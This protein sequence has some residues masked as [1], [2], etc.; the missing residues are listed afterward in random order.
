MNLRQYAELHPVPEPEEE[1]QAAEDAAAI[2]DRRQR[3]QEEAERL[4]ES[5]SNQLDEG[6]FPQNVLYTALKLIGLLSHDQDWGE[7]QQAKIDK[8]YAGLEQQNFFIDNQAVAAKRLQDAQQEYNAKLRRQ[9]NRNI[10]QY[11]KIE[12]QLRGII[13]ALDELEGTTQNG[14][15]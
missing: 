12:S 5:I 4:K 13:K 15:S 10:A 9:I 1:R 8:V 3:E 7:A 11:V 2:I 14:S 6:Y